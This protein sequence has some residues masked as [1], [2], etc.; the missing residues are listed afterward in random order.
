MGLLGTQL[1][2]YAIECTTL[3]L[4]ECTLANAN[5]AT[6]AKRVLAIVLWWV[7][8]SPH[9]LSPLSECTLPGITLATFAQNPL[10]ECTLVGTTLATL[11]QPSTASATQRVLNSQ[12]LPRTASALY[13]T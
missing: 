10:S 13:R 8:H 2:T 7:P 5:L 1:A 3:S 9:S 4:D 6:L 11:A 12:H